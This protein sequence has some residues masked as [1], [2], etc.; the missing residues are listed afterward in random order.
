M[1]HS[2]QVAFHDALES[3]LVPIEMV[4]CA[5]YNY[6]NGDV[7]EIV[8]SIQESGMYR[9][10]QAQKST[11]YVLMGNHTLLAC[12]E[13]GSEVMPVVWLDVDDVEAKRMMLADNEIPRLARP[14][15][16]LMLALLHE[17]EEEIGSVIGTGVSRETMAQMEAITRMPLDTDRL[18]PVTDNWPTL[19]IQMPPELLDGFLDFT[20][21]EDNRARFEWLMREAGWQ[22]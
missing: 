19:S 12:Q 16:G 20:D 10:V 14:D 18:Q 1:I 15:D 17:V 5:P 9:P 21:G 22:G 7:E 8:T 4:Q 2:G 3:L 11:G 6:N 13:L